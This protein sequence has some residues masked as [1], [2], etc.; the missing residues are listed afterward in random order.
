MDALR[1]AGIRANA[2]LSRDNLKTQLN[3]AA[4]VGALF[5]LIIGQKE[6]V[7]N[8]VIVRD[9]NEGVQETVTEEK[10]IEKLKAKLKTKK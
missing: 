3:I 1:R 4:K 7:D 8:T 10:L 5:A 2:S 9:M 6:A